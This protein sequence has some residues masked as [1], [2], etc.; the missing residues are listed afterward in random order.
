MGKRKSIN[1]VK[2]SPEQ[3][4]H[5]ISRDILIY[6]VIKK[7]RWYIQVN[8]YGNIK[9]FDKPILEKD[10]NEAISKTIIFYY[11]KITD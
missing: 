6:P 8:N 11:K 1:T 9:T 4:Y 7:S 10:I 3:I 5:L 2:A